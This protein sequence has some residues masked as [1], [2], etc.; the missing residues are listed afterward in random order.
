M[1][2][3]CYGSTWW[4]WGSLP[5]LMIQWFYVAVMCVYLYKLAARW[6]AFTCSCVKCIHMHVCTYM[7]INTHTHTHIYIYTFFLFLMLPSCGLTQLVS[8]GRAVLALAG[9]GCASTPV[10]QPQ[11]G[12]ICP[13]PAGK[14]WVE[15]TFTSLVGF[16]GRNNILCYSS[17]SRGMPYACC[18][19]TM[20]LKHFH[21]VGQY[22]C[23]NVTVEKCYVM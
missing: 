20:S 22:V 21:F 12:V 8:Q 1:L 15:P 23:L 4:A 3:L 10:L 14:C 7:C 5:A 11:C 17:F 18:C 9:P 6:K 13:A 2:E 16:L 19:S